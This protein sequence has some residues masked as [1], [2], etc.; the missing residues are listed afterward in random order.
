MTRT[1]K[2]A[3]LPREVRQMLNQRM[4]NGARGKDLVV[5]LNSL[6]EVK[7]GL[8]AGF[9]GAPIT[10]SNLSIWRR[11]G[12]DWLEQQQVAETA[13]QLMQAVAEHGP[14]ADE[15]TSS[16]G[17]SEVLALE[18]GR[19]AQLLLRAAPHGEEHRRCLRRI[20]RHVNAMRRGGWSRRLAPLGDGAK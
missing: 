14:A 3:R 7:A 18:L 15:A 5:W 19:T 17:L 11:G 2:I 1:G 6:P 16:K 9:G 12:W 10:E 20:T 4:E 13:K 8:A